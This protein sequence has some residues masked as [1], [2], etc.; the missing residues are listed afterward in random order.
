MFQVVNHQLDAWKKPPHISRWII[1]SL[2]STIVL[3]YTT[4]ATVI[5]V[6]VVSNYVG[7][8][9]FEVAKYVGGLTTLYA[10]WLPK[11]MAESAGVSTAKL[12]QV[13]SV[14]LVISEV[15]AVSALVFLTL[16]LVLALARKIRPARVFGLLGFT[17]GLVVPVLMF[18]VVR[19]VAGQMANDRVVLDVLSVPTG[20]KLQ[21]VAAIAG[22]ACVL[23]ATKNAANAGRALKQACRCSKSCLHVK[24]NYCG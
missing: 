8:N 7:G 14:V 3:I 21:L 5:Q 6:P 15:I 20:P 11:M 9:I 19:V 18:T 13:G 24:E 4:F 17:L 22:C 16:H 2:I 1:G 10:P 23:L 12:L